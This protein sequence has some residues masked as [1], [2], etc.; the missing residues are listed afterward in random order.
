MSNKKI[1]EDLNTLYEFIKDISIYADVKNKV[2]TAIDNYSSLD[3]DVHLLEEPTDTRSIFYNFHINQNAYLC[4]ENICEE[5]NDLN[6]FADNADLSY[7][8]NM[9]VNNIIHSIL[10]VFAKYKKQYSDF[11]QGYLDKYGKKLITD[12]INKIKKYIDELSNQFIDKDK[13]NELR[14]IPF[15]DE[16]Q[17]E[18]HKS[19]NTVLLYVYCIKSIISQI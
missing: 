19:T 8:A 3:Y 17:Q 16:I 6:N 10:V 5:L 13:Q 1:L 9:D 15:I 11:Q 4:L 14:S 2:K 18:F 7:T 12:N